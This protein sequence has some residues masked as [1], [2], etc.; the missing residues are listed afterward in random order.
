MSSSKICNRC[1]MDDTSE[2]LVLDENGVCN[3]CHIAQKELSMINNRD[4]YNVI[5]KMDKHPDKYDCLIGLSGGVDSSTT[6]YYARFLG[7]NPLCFTM[8]NGF[9]DPRADEN[10]LKLVE[11]LKVPLYRY[12]LDIEKFKEVQKAYIEAGLINVEAVYDHCLMAA[13]YEM[14]DRYGIKWIFSGGNVATESI[15]P[16][17]WSYPARDLWNIKSIYKWATGKKL[18]GIPTCGILKFNWYKWIKRI[19]IFYP[20]DCLEYNRKK[21][22]ELLK[23]KFGFQSTGEKHEENQ[24]TKWFQNCYLPLKFKIDKRKAHFSSLINAGHMTRQEAIE[25]LEEPLSFKLIYKPEEF[26]VYR[27]RSHYEFKSD[28][29]LWKLLGN[30]VKMLRDPYRRLTKIIKS[31]VV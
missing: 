13:S 16:A 23:D 29:K 21:S 14:A 25:K 24:F 8:D 22:E 5:D 30:L 6:L 18:K 26:M 31:M 28:E 15:M 17:S 1:V 11:T 27:K 12:V 4:L 7:L 10:I 9:N 19:K 3:F 20:L 2:E